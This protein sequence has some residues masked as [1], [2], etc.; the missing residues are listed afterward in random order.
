MT[1]Y[2]SFVARALLQDSRVNADL[3]TRHIRRHQ[4]DLESTKHGLLAHKIRCEVV[5]PTVV[6]RSSHLS[7]S[8]QLLA[9][10]T[11]SDMMQL[12]V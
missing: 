10:L 5:L 2:G 3:A 4:G 12:L 11:R 8:N 6:T 7:M 9:M 1:Q